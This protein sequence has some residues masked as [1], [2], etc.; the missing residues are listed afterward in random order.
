MRKLTTSLITKALPFLKIQNLKWPLNIEMVIICVS[1]SRCN[2]NQ[3]NKS[4]AKLTMLTTVPPQVISNYFF[5][6]NRWMEEGCHQVQLSLVSN[7]RMIY[8]EIFF[9]PGLLPIKCI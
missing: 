3:G 1:L 7:K 8:I 6:S 4:F 9:Q 5:Q 2:P